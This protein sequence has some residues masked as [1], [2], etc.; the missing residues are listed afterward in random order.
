MKI[1]HSLLPLLAVVIPPL[2]HGQ[3]TIPALPAE[4][5]AARRQSVVNLETHIKQRENRAQ[6]IVADIRALDA[7]VEKGVDDI[8][9]MIS[10]V[11]DSETSKVRV[12]NTKVEVMKG[13]RKTIEYYNQ[14]RDTLREELR[15]GKS[16]QSKDTLEKDLAI[17]DARVEKRVDQ[18]LEIAKSFPDPQELAKYETSLTPGWNGLLYA[19]EEISP[20]WK[21]NRRDS[22][23]TDQAREGVDKALKD[24]IDQMQQ[25]NV[26]LNGKLQSPTLPDAEKEYYRYEIQR[27]NAIIDLRN[28][29]LEDFATGD[30]TPAATV[31]Q[32]QAHDMDELVRSSR[33]DLREDFFAIFRKYD[34]LNRIRADV[35]Q[36][37]ENQAAR[38]AWLEK[39]DKQHP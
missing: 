12:A 20:E 6:N 31:P 11:K 29:D 8:V 4:E 21:Q 30:A 34:E 28:K 18:I 22:R 1:P 27:N 10:K 17:F 5:L 15:T 13:L 36:L 25:R 32:E 23:N 26:Y 38:K 16:D 37:Q 19:N 9:N 39:Y 2:L 33:D 3:D 35:K 7:R 24:S 14:H